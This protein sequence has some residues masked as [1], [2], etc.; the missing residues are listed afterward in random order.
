M[1]HRYGQFNCLLKWLV[2]YTLLVITNTSSATDTK[3]DEAP[4][5]YGNRTIAIE[6]TQ[7]TKQDIQ[8]QRRSIAPAITG[9]D[10]NRSLSPNTEF[11]HPH[12][13]VPVKADTVKNTLDLNRNEMLLAKKAFYY[14]ERNW[15]ETTGLVDSVQ[16]YPHTT[17]WDIASVLAATISAE[18]LGII[19]LDQSH[20]R[21][22]LLLETLATLPLYDNRLPNREYNTRTAQ[23][24]GRY[25]TSPSKGN[26]WSALDIGRL[27]LWLDITRRYHPEHQKKIEHI[28]KRWALDASI[29]DTNLYGELKTGST[30]KYRQE[31]RLGYLQYAATGFKLSGFDVSNAFDK[32]DT[33]TVNVDGIDLLADNR[34]LPYFTSDPYV[35]YAIEI[36]QNN[37]WWDQLDPLFTLQKQKSNKEQSLWIFA[38]DALNRAPWFSYNNIFIYGKSWL[39]TAPGGKTIENPQIFS[40]KVGFGF[41]VLFPDDPFSQI[42]SEA[43]ISHS[44]AHRSIPTGIYQNG[45][46]NT[47]Y[48]INTNSLILAALW[49]KHRHYRPLIEQGTVSAR[50]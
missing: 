19:A 15:Q 29:K 18:G 2:T 39:S 24:S 32:G 9:D 46:P 47:A 50:P 13:I 40:N 7:P 6:I 34:N 33:L 5:F 8:F 1:A 3:E 23:P 48:N 42:L 43:V 49:Y 31:G 35:L 30:V 16:G 22:E 44:L 21:I 17:M 14:F 38:E 36:G 28:K 12:I 37:A 10:T 26:G 20:Q 41:S 25:S 45:G 11:H 4:S 27:L